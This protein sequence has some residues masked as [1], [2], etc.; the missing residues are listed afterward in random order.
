MIM[1]DNYEF[2]NTSAVGNICSR[3]KF[4]FPNDYISIK[5]LRCLYTLIHSCKQCSL[6]QIAGSGF[7]YVSQN[8]FLFQ[9]ITIWML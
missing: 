6:D 8:P 4:P 7:T 9:R 5:I 2:G 1:G 3:K